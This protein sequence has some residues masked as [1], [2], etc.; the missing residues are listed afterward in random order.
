MNFGNI[1]ILILFLSI[2]SCSSGEFSSDPP[3]LNEAVDVDIDQD[4]LIDY[5]ITYVQPFSRLCNHYL[6]TLVPGAG[7]EVLSK[8]E[9]GSLF[10]R[11][12]NMIEYDLEEPLYWNGDVFV[13]NFLRIK[14]LEEG[15]P[16]EWEILSDSLYDSYFIGLKF[17]SSEEGLLGW[18]EVDTDEVGGTV[19]VKDSGIVN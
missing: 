12:L 7:N 10:L 1:S 15:W 13:H 11:D 5:R 17:D 2:V 16:N 9:E 18:I 8:K 14:E 4:G 3:V 19:N 6:L